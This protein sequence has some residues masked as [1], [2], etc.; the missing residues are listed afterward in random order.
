MIDTSSRQQVPAILFRWLSSVGIIHDACFHLNSHVCK[1]ASITEETTWLLSVSQPGLSS[2]LY[3]TMAYCLQWVWLYGMIYRSLEWNNS[4]TSLK[5]TGFWRI[6][7]SMRSRR[8]KMVKINFDWV[9]YL[10]QRHNL[11]AWVPCYWYWNQYHNLIKTFFQRA[12][13][14]VIII[15]TI[16]IITVYFLNNFIKTCFLLS[17]FF[18]YDIR[19]LFWWDG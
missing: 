15:I 17:V 5:V 18:K 14:K 4:A 9:K 8:S 1:P 6:M 19:M 3:I 13:E 2:V 12:A 11:N 7:S 10:L 16:I